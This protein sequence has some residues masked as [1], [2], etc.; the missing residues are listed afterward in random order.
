MKNSIF[1]FV[2]AASAVWAGPVYVNIP[3]PQP[4][5]V[6]SLGYEATS[7]QEF[8][9]LIELAGGVP[10]TL[11]SATVLMS[12]WSK[13]STY[14]TVGTTAGF[15]VPLTLNLYNVGPGN[16]LGSLFSSV[17]TNANILWR[18]EDSAGC[19]GAWRAADNACY[20]GFAQTVSFTLAGVSA[21]AQLIYGLAFNTPHHGYNPIGG[22]G[23]T[24]SLNFGLNTASPSVGSNPLPGTAF[25]NTSHGPFYAD[26]GAGGTNTFRSDTL[27]AP[28][29]G[30][31]NFE[32]S[33]I[34][35][36][37]TYALM[38]AGLGLLV[39]LRRRK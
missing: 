12:N 29:S 38:A 8:G 11:T 32:A 39:F 10:A 14:Q 9:G 30:A 18:P 27:W 3:N 17:T 34:P 2:L 24:Q 4:Y 23:P 6:P 31:I 15:V 25:W 5:N 35:E 33:D 37:G 21:P 16:T 20:N 1:A 7:T 28:Y 19:N 13:E 22:N 26:G 36:P